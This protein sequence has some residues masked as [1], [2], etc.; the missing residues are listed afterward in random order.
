MLAVAVL[1]LFLTAMKACREREFSQLAAYHAQEEAKWRRSSKGWPSAQQLADY[2]GCMRR[3]YQ[4]ASG[5]AII[6]N[7]PKPKMLPPP[8]PAVPWPAPLRRPP[9]REPPTHRLVPKGS[10][11]PPHRLD[12]WSWIPPAIAA[13]G[14]VGP[15]L[16][17]GTGD[18]RPGV[19]RSVA[20]RS[21]SRA[22]AAGR[23]GPRFRIACFHF[24]RWLQES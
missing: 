21:Q 6:P 17:A 14:N 9:N 20:R 23:A 2:H 4:Q 15:A 5:F 3:A 13:P 7:L 11:P 16:P 22:G 1:C 8:P 19:L 10:F 24:V 12:E 18:G